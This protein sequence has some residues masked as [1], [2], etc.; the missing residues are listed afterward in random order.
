MIK[1]NKRL[2]YE[3]IMRKVSNIVKR[4]LLE[5]EEKSEVEIAADKILKNLKDIGY[6]SDDDLRTTIDMMD[7]LS[8]NGQK[9]K[10]TFFND[11]PYSE[12][13]PEL[14][15]RLKSGKALDD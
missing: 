6:N 4:S 13:I 11:V 7:V 10:T 8:C 1:R 9:R 15:K 3:K 2:I 12:L 14:E 5:A